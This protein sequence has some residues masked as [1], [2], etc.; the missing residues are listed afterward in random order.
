MIWVRQERNFNYSSV[1]Y[2]AEQRAGHSEY[3]VHYPNSENVLLLF[4]KDALKTGKY[5]RTGHETKTEMYMERGE[6]ER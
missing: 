5:C 4:I 6:N 2:K 3:P 1:V